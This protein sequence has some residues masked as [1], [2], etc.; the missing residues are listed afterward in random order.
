VTLPRPPHTPPSQRSVRER[1]S[2]RVVDAKLLAGRDVPLSLFSRQ[3][4]RLG[5]FEFF[6]RQGA[7][8]VQFVQTL[9]FIETLM[10]TF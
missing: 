2:G 6:V 1:R 3:D 4:L 7:G 5:L 10:M 8:L 9:D